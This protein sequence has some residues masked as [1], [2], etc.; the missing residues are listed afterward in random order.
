MKKY[1]L[2]IVSVLTF[3]SCSDFLDRYPNDALSPSTFWKTENDAKLALVGCYSGFESGWTVL[4][5]DNASDNAYN[6]HGHEGWQVIGN[7]TMSAG[8]P[9]NTQYGYGII[10]RCNEFLE[11]IDKITFSDSQKKENYIAEARFLRAYRYFL[12]TQELGDVP[13]VKNTFATPDEAKVPRDSRQTVEQF[14][15]DELK[16][17]TPK[18]A[19]SYDGETGRVTRNAGHALLA[20]VYLFKKMY[21]EAIDEAKKIEGADLYPDFEG[22]FLLANEKNNE[23][24]LEISFT[25]AVEPDR[26]IKS[27]IG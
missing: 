22:L 17:L 5:R 14:V 19:T 18:L 16:D 24:L 27:A 9:G 11:N 6:Y 20:R 7:G 10:R 15:I 26:L 3:T 12:M 2:L 23:V 8:T 4:C 13:L 25:F 1:I 21:Q